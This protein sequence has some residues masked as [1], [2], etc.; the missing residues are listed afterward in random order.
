MS[1][2]ARPASVPRR[3]TARSSLDRHE[4]GCSAL[5]VALVHDWIVRPG[6]GERVLWTM[7]EAF[8][9]AP[10]YTS[11]YRPEGLPQFLECDVR[12]SYLGRWPFTKVSHQFFSSLRSSVFESFDFRDY[13]VV[14]SSS[15]AE[16]KG[17]LTGPETLH[18][19]YMYTPTRYYWSEYQEYLTRPGFGRLSGVVQ[20]LMPIVVSGRRQWDFAAAQRPDRVIAISLNVAARIE[21]Y[22]RRTPDAVIYPPIEIEQ[23]RPGPEKPS[24][25][26]VVSRLIP[27]KRI[28]LAV[29]A[30][31]RLSR[32][33]TVVGGG[34]ELDNLRRLAGPHTTF[35]GTVDDVTLA[36]HLRSAEALL[37][38][39]EE[40]FGMVP[41]EAMACGRP[42]IAF[43]KGGAVESVIDG[44]TGVLFAEQSVDSLIDAIERFDQMEFDPVVAR[45][46]AE[47]FATR[48]FVDALTTY[49]DDAYASFRA[50]RTPQSTNVR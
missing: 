43:G 1:D 47:Q 25:F 50:G 11:I 44:K 29:E 13:D 20:A 4:G 46:Q 10:I 49:V 40:D 18:I 21:K 41:L 38:P 8:P 48:A 15:S 26:L 28:D 12:S 6:G 33:L 32:P 42:V 9:D 24:G 34:G 16:A 5:K 3:Y 17:V 37:F 19:C 7:H 36:R 39:G 31:R 22:Y 30:C 45:T 27:Y 2:P 35:V 14:I 23:F